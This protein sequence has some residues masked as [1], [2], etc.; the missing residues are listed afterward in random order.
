MD[1]FPETKKKLQSKISRYK[2]DLRKQKK[3]FGFIRDGSGKRYILFCLLFVFN[4]LEKAE[5]YFNWYKEEF[6]DDIGE[7]IQ[8][9]CWALSLH[10]MG[11]ENE[12]RYRLADAML[13]N[14]YIIPIILGIDIKP[15]DMWH[16]SNYEDIDY[17]EYIPEEVI[18]SITESEIEWIKEH[19][20]STEF[21]Q[22]RERYIEIFH[23]IK[24]TDNLEVRRKLLNESRSLLD[25]FQKE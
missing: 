19:Y 2:S 1:I 13:S 9:L 8:K 16:G 17:V 14:L 11:K 23:H 12:A 22:V 5:K 24:S 3:E 25:R 7:P 15:Y 20:H 6:P 18:D 4:D 10:R 21:I